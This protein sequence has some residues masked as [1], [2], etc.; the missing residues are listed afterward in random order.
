MC[1]FNFLDNPKKILW[2]VHGSGRLFLVISLPGTNQLT[3][4]PQ[5]WFNLLESQASGPRTQKMVGGY[6]T[7]SSV[8]PCCDWLKHTKIVLARYVLA[9]AALMS[10]FDLTV[11]GANLT[12]PTCTCA[13]LAAAPLL[14]AVSTGQRGLRGMSAA[15]GHTYPGME[16]YSST[17]DLE[18]C[19]VRVQM[20]DRLLHI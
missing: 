4:K 6:I 16:G 14:P 15:T 13:F 5:N 7:L 20:R 1:N 12:A 17:T 2:V 19:A 18:T 11:L 3:C 10:I 8:P 9:L